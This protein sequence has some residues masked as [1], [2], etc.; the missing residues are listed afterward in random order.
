MPSPE[1]RDSR[2]G[3][4]DAASRTTTTANPPVVGDPVHALARRISVV[5]AVGLAACQGDKTAPVVDP[6]SISDGPL[7]SPVFLILP[8]PPAGSVTSVFVGDSVQLASKLSTKHSRTISW[9][10]SNATV[11]RVN[12]KGLAVA[13]A[14]GFAIITASNANGSEQWTF[15]VS[16][17]IASVTVTPNPASLLVG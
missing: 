17:R 2:I 3:L 10:S 6:S 15:N 12:S 4:S 13:G 8:S 7:G 16:Q 9:S 1:Q 11:M 14:V 5:V